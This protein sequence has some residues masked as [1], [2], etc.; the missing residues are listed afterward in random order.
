MRIMIDLP[1][2]P[3]PLARCARRVLLAAIAALLGASAHAD[4][5]KAGVTP[6]Q[7]KKDQSQCE[8]RA[9]S[10]A[11]FDRIDPSGPGTRAGATLRGTGT[12]QRET[13]NFEFCMRERGYDWVDPKAVPKKPQGE[14]QQKDAEAE[15]G[16]S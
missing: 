5:Q 10:E 7:L 13:R 14:S 2:R 4:W 12:A 1:S 3:S 16:K 11:Q 15:K 9:R 6:E 8:I